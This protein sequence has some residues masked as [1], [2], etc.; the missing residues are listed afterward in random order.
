M[1]PPPTPEPLWVESVTSPTERL[2]QT[3]TVR[4]GR[5]REVVVESV[6]GSTTVSGT[7]G[8][9]VYPARVT[10]PLLPDTTHRLRVTGKVEYYPGC[11]YTLLTRRD[12]QGMPLVIVQ[13]K[14]SSIYL[15]MTARGAADVAH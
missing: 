2:T 11:F 3:I 12:R 6:A 14:Q 15:P 5:G 10:I 8:A 9:Y 1:D 13:G 4:L 7:Y